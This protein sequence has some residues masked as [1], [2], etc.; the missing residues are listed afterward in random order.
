M[1]L[2]LSQWLM[3]VEESCG[4]K[5]F[6]ITGKGLVFLEKYLELQNITGTKN[7]QKSMTVAPE[8]QRVLK[9]S[10]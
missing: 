3:L 6:M 4:Q 10:I 9:Q 2:L 7:K 5:K 8:I 1:Q